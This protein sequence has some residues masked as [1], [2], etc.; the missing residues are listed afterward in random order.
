MET[1]SN[2]NRLG[3]LIHSAG[4]R[5][6]AFWILTWILLVVILAEM[7]DQDINL[8]RWTE[9]QSTI[10]LSLLAS[11]SVIYF[12][13]SVLLPT[14]LVSRKF[15][16]HVVQLFGCILL[17]ALVYAELY[18]LFLSGNRNGMPSLTRFGLSFT[19]TTVLVIL[20][21]SWYVSKR[22]QE[23][24]KRVTEIEQQKVT[25][26]LDALKAQLNP[27]FLFNTLN[28][29][30]A[31][32]LEGSRKSSD[33]ILR[34]S[35][36]MRYILYECRATS[37]PLRKEIDF[38]RNY[39]ELERVRSD[40]SIRIEF[41]AD[42]SA[43]DKLVAPLLMIPFIENAFKHGVKEQLGNSFVRIS[44]RM[45]DAE[46]LHFVIENSKPEDSQVTGDNGIGIGIANARKR[47]AL[48][49]PDEHKLCIAD[50]GMTYRVD[51]TID[52]PSA[53]NLPK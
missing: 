5:H 24:Y 26:E 27:H 45:L 3:H 29:I 7:R 16:R 39:L 17:S 1:N 36:M 35:E 47:L 42:E 9:V 44:L 19:K 31:L 50:D 11:A 40:K 48:I 37:V 15:T 10:T 34:L 30:Y 2:Q 6:A 51:L 38:I 32:S 4:I 53:G 21:S 28:N 20:T 49:Y 22:Y 8:F 43:A 33:L 46:K 25:I 14:Y 41:D 13:L 52:L 12:N 23:M 18:Q